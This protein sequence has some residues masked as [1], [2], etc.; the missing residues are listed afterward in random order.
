MILTIGTTE[1]EIGIREFNPDFDSGVEWIQV[2]TKWK[3]ID[4]GAETA[5]WSTDITVAEFGEAVGELR[6][7]ILDAMKSGLSIFVECENHEPIFGPEFS[8]NTSI[9]CSIDASEEPFSTGNLN[10]NDLVEWTFTIHPLVDMT[11]LYVAN[12]GTMP[13]TGLRMLSAVRLD[14]AG[15]AFNDSEVGSHSELAGLGFHAPTAEIRYEGLRATVAQALAYLQQRR[16]SAMS[17]SAAIVWP[18]EQSVLSASVYVQDV[19]LD[20]YTD[21]AC[22]MFGFT[23]V[24]GKV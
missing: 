20:G 24:Y 10:E 5:R 4:E 8:Y 18:F 19:E 3:P 17:Y 16:G 6:G 14:N 1:Y 15:A 11:T 2:G 9:S 23:V 13:A 12:T 22:T 21:K 7:A